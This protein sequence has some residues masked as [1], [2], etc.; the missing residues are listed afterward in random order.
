MDKSKLMMIIIIALLVILLG[1]VVAVTF[2]LFNMM[3]NEDPTEFHVQPPT[4][5]AGNIS[6]MD[7]ISVPLGDTRISTNL[8]IGSDG[9]SGMVMTEVVVGVNGTADEAEVEAFVNAFNSRISLARA[10]AV[11]VFGEHT[12]D[13]VRT[14]EGRSALGETIMVRLQENFETNL[15]VTVRFSDWALSRGR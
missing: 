13:Q 6:M 10:I 3:G 8:A 1:T 15:I 14:P 2:F 12:Y 9:F 11:E 5:V 7:L 4:V